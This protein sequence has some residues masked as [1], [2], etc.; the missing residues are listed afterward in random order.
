MTERNDPA[1]I[2]IS[3]QEEHDTIVRIL[4]AHGVTAPDAVR[5]ADVLLE[6]DLR[7][8]HSHGIRR[9]PVLAARLDSGV[10]TSGIEP[11]MEW[12]GSSRLEVDG[13]RGL[14]P[15]V[16]HKVLDEIIRRAEETG[17][18]VASVSNSGH[19]GMLAPYTERMADEGV[20]GIVLTTS[21]ALVAPWGGSRAMVGTNPIG[22]GIPTDDEPLVL[23]MSTAAVSAGKVLDYAARGQELPPGWAVDEH[24]EPTTDASAA[25]RGA[26]SPYGGAKGFALG[27][28]LGALIGVLAD[29]A[30]G[31][32][33]FGTLD[34]DR[35][36]TKGDLFIALPVRSESDAVHRL[37][38]Y[39][40]QLRS[41]GT[42]G[43]SVLIPGDRARA[44]RAERLEHGIPL[45]PELWSSIIRMDASEHRRRA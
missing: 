15:A 2:V 27:V 28:A 19:L 42:S 38:A 34:T 11:A 1:T 3:A 20:I 5:Q 33:V 4:R 17:A 12:Q 10:T 39:L 37:T 13:R 23:D 8:Q 21:E 35:A 18:A 25:T 31:R 41:E 29:T 36:P 16:A 40:D 44:M 32:D 45:D 22:I 30:F 14:G 9:L 24:G 43:R 6:G 7:G 26:I